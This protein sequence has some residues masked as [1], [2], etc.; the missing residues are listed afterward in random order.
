VTSPQEEPVLEQGRCCFL[1][2]E[3]RVT[4][5]GSVGQPQL[6]TVFL[7]LLHFGCWLALLLALE[8]WCGE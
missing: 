4:C 3:H 7:S 2:W 6:S 8:L 1:V 5:C